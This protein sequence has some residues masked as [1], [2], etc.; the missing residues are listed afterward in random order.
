MAGTVHG[1]IDCFSNTGTHYLNAQEVFVGIYA[2]FAANPRWT[3]KA[4]YSGDN[5]GNIPAGSGRGF[6][7]HDGTNPLGGNAFF[8][9]E[10]THA[11]KKFYTLFQ[12]IDGSLSLPNGTINNSTSGAGIGVQMACGLTSGAVV[13]NPYQGSMD[14]DGADTKTG[15]WWEAPGVTGGSLYVFPRNNSEGGSFATDRN[16]L[17]RMLSSQTAQHRY[18]IVADDDNFVIA[19]DQTSGYY[20]TTGGLYAP[21]PDLTSLVDFPLVMLVNG[22]NIGGFQM[23]GSGAY[24]TSGTTVSQDGGIRGTSYLVGASSSD[25]VFPCAIDELTLATSGSFQPNKAFQATA[26]EEWPLFLCAAEAPSAYGMLGTYDF[27]R[28]SYN[29]A[30]HTLRDPDSDRVW[31]GDGNTSTNSRK[32]SIPWDGVTVPGSGV[33]R[34]GVGF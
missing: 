33:V 28:H 18:H 23:F 14:N 22:N 24:G 10:A 20:L 19:V 3:I 4:K 9:V 15:T 11:A 30:S 5:G 29:V 7:Y 12:F 21:R 13:G 26:I 34:E 1:K 16:N 6:D 17:A 31:L 8:M 2:F 25:D 32:T 27:V